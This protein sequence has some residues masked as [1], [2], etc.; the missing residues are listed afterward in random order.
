MGDDGR[1]H[2]AGE[3]LTSGEVARLFGVSRRTVARWA[4]E[5]KLTVIRTLGGH[6]RFYAGDVYELLERS[7]EDR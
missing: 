3:L 5:G 1:E 7:P 6:R 4:D 2:D